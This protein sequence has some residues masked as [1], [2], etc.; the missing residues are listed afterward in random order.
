M[1]GGNVERLVECPEIQLEIR[2]QLD[3]DRPEVSS[4]LARP[5]DEELDGRPRLLESADVGEVAAGL[6]R[7]KE[8]V[9]DPDRPGSRSGSACILLPLRS[10]C[11]FRARPIAAV[12]ACLAEISIGPVSGLKPPPGG[13]RSCP[14]PGLGA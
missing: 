9:R 13:M 11:H 4:Q 8:V 5:L 14:W 7:E 12:E 6:D 10:E 2:R 1:P 3:Q